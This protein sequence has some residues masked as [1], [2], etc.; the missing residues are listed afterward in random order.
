MLDNTPDEFVP[1]LQVCREFGFTSM[2]LYRTDARPHLGF[3]PPVYLGT[4]KYRSRKMLE[5]YKQRLIAEAV[6][7]QQQRRLEVTT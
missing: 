3:P 5:A 1:D 4:R 7:K 2:T 6:A